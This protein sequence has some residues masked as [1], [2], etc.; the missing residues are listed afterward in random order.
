MATTGSGGYFVISLLLALALSWASLTPAAHGSTVENAAQRANL[1]ANDAVLDG[2]EAT[3]S[4]AD[5]TEAW[6]EWAKQKLAASV[7]CVD[8]FIHLIN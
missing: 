4:W 5:T 8:Q 3:E 1:A 7:N 6:A 2:K